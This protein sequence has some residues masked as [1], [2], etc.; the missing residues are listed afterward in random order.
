VALTLATYD[1]QSVRPL[2]KRLEW[3][4]APLWKRAIVVTK[5][6]WNTRLVPWLR[7]AKAVRRP[8]PPEPP[9]AA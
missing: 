3:L 6:W 2:R 7:R 5:R 8:V 9:P 1:A 4:E